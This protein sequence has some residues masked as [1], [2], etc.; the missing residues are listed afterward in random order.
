[1]AGPLIQPP[2]GQPANIGVSPESL[3]L[4]HL[5]RVARNVDNKRAVQVHLSRLRPYNRREHHIRIAATTFDS[6]LSNLE[7]QNFV[8]SNGDLF[9][10]GQGGTA[11]DIDTAAMKVRHL[12]SDDPLTHGDTEDDILRFYT[13]YN[14]EMQIDDLMEMVRQMQRDRERR[15]R[16]GMGRSGGQVGPAKRML[17]PRFMTKLEEFLSRGDLTRLLRRQPVV[18][19]TPGGQAQPVFRE[20]YVSVSELQQMIAP[21]LDMTGDVWLFQYLTQTL[22]NRILQTLTSGEDAVFNGSFSINLNIQSVL[23]PLFVNFDGSLK[24]VARGT[25]IVELQVIDIFGDMSSYLF[26]RDFLRERGYRICLDGL[27]HQ[28]VKFIERE[29]LGLDLMKLSWNPTLI[30]DMSARHYSELKDSVDHCGRARIILTRVDSDD[31][32]KFGHQLG[33]T[34]FQGFHVDKMLAAVGKG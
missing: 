26:A 14:L 25:V 32:I 20:L 18:A 8:L 34:M 16:A 19:L 6:M 17:E 3:L 1:M 21:D 9:W 27:N 13:W 4:D 15:L 5:Q 12:F 2:P 10:V 29:R 28:T 30:E 33:I 11:A 31:A 24:A 7:G 22:D 23:S